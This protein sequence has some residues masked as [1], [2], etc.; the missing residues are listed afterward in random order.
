MKETRS[1]SPAR[2]G[3]ADR[4][5]AANNIRALID[6]PSSADYFRS[7]IGAMSKAMKVDQWPQI[8][9]SR[10]NIIL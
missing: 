5:C 8:S 7:E 2:L 6:D 1:G 4:R 10:E 9:Q 3:V